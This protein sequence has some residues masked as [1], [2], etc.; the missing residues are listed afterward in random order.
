MLSLDRTL[1]LAR[2]FPGLVLDPYWIALDYHKESSTNRGA[3]N[4]ALMTLWEEKRVEEEKGGST[5]CLPCFLP[6]VLSFLH[7]RRGVQKHNKGF[8]WL[9]NL[10][11]FYGLYVLAQD[12]KRVLYRFFPSAE[13]ENF[14]TQEEKEDEELPVSVDT[15]FFPLSLS[16]RERERVVFRFRRSQVT[17][18]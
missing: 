14:S 2:I 15:V 9:Q 1:K 8:K 5:S 10:L 7:E 12:M 18:E 3:F 16:S 17:H 11:F 13:K 6:A 4:C